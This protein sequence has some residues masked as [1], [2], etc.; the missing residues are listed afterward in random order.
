[1]G[2]IDTERQENGLPM[3]SQRQLYLYQPIRVASHDCS[4]AASALVELEV[5]DHR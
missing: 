4:M 2:G 1:M 5:P 3:L